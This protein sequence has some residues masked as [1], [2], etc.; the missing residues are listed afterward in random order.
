MQSSYF[1][2]VTGRAPAELRIDNVRI[3]DVLCGWLRLPSSVPCPGGQ[4]WCPQCRYCP[5]RRK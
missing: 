4:V 3:V 5:F 2:M 1:D